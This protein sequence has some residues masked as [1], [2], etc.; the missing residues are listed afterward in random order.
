MLGAGEPLRINARSGLLT[1]RP[2]ILGQFVVGICVDEYDRKT[3][4]L[5]A[6]TRRDFQYNV[7]NC[8][9][10]TAAF[11][12][13]ET[14]CD[15][16]KV[17]FR[18]ESIGASSYLWLFDAPRSNLI[19]TDVNPI[20]TFP[21]YN[22]YKVSLIAPAKFEKLILMNAEKDSDYGFQTLAIGMTTIFI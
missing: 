1:A 19:S 16:T 15:S 20:F 21:A 12:A 7:Q 22:T 3:K 8:E 2:G 14:Q 9:G 18:N 4:T 17:R 5:I 13:P 6:S 10:V 11:F